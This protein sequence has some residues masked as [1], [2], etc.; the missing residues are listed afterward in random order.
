[1]IVNVFLICIFQTFYKKITGLKT[2]LSG[3]EQVCDKLLLWICNSFGEI[4][5]FDS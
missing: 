5:T 1:M 3:P 4:T 2:D